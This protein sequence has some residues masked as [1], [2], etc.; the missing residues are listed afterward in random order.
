MILISMSLFLAA[1]QTSVYALRSVAVA[2]PRISTKLVLLL[3][4]SPSPSSHGSS[5]NSEIQQA[6]TSSL[7][8]NDINITPSTMPPRSKNNKHKIRTRKRKQQSESSFQKL[9]L[10]EEEEEE[11][12]SFLFE[13]LQQ[14][15][16]A[17]PASSHYQQSKHLKH[18]DQHLV[19][20]LNADYQPLSHAPLSLWSWQD[21]IKALFSGKVTVVDTYHPNVL[22]RA[23]NINVPLPSVIAIL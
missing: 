14:Q 13:A 17:A 20:V 8:T 6:S 23:V 1:L 2:S 21:A 7:E 9:L 10:E 5:S 11:Q 15:G 19:L 4:T 3:H 22:I 12:R 16:E 18:L